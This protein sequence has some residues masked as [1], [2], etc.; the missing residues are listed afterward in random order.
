MEKSTFEQI[1][2]LI[3]V[4]INDK[5]SYLWP[6]NCENC[7]Y[8]IRNYY[9]V[10]RNKVMP[11][12]LESVAAYEAGELNFCDCRA[13]QS[14]RGW[15]ETMSEKLKLGKLEYQNL[16]K[17][18]AEKKQSRLFDNSG[19]PPA[20][21]NLKFITYFERCR[22]DKGKQTALNVIQEFSATGSAG[23][24]R[25][26]MLWGP[27][28]RGKTGSLSPLFVNL[29]KLSNDGLWIQ[30]NDLLAQLRRFDDGKVD[31]RMQECQRTK[32][33][34]IDDLGDPMAEKVTDYTRDVMFRII[35]YRCNNALTTFI[36][37]NL[38]PTEL[39]ALFHE[40]FVKRI[41]NLCAII[42]VGGNALGVLRS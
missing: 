14:A 16:Q 17:V 22:N 38:S 3:P 30:Y 6:A 8:G 41:G 42:H 5:K 35:D 13:G 24:K 26:I 32:L 36:T 20:F 40:R 33:L 19:V 2:D 29:L 11:L 7:Q 39:S 31:E 9:N 25:G 1:S 18:V 21:R 28:D 27:S 34:F 10:I 37:S 12:Y 4:L 23:G 15:H